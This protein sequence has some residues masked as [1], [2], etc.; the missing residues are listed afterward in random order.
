MKLLRQSLLTFWCL[1]LVPPPIHAIE[2]T[3]Q[4]IGVSDGD[5]ITVLHGRHQQRV[6]LNG[7]DCPERGQSWSKKAKQFTSFMVFDRDVTVREFGR[8]KYG[9]IIAGVITPEG[10]SLNH[11]LVREGLA[12]WYRKHPQDQSENV[13]IQMEANRTA[14]TLMRHAIDRRLTSEQA[15]PVAP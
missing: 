14:L 9:R 1:V 7:I 6:R 4:V 2:F 13:A 15:T 11:E 3:A 8:D 5:T 12:W 10:K